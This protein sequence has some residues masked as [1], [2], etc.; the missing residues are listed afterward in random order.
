[1]SAEI[2]SSVTIHIVVIMMKIYTALPPPPPPPPPADERFI[3]WCSQAEVL[4]SL[5]P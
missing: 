4:P 5:T 3:I 1:M 2:G